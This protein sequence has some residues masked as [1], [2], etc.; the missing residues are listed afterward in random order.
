MD[1]AGIFMSFIKGIGLQ[2]DIDLNILIL[3][4]KEFEI[5]LRRIE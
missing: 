4:N 1:S 2:K 5:L 3:A